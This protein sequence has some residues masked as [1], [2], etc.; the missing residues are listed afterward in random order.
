MY[1]AVIL[2]YTAVILMYTAVILMYT[3]VILPYTAVI[4]MY[5]AV[6]LPYTA[7]ILMYTAVILM[8]TAVILSAAK[9]LIYPL[10]RSFTT[11][12]MTNRFQPLSSNN[13]SLLKR[14]SIQY[15]KDYRQLLK[16]IMR[17]FSNF[18]NCICNN[19]NFK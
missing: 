17:H 3:A 13:S 5:T 10:Q 12:R 8:Y 18:K 6:I 14:P 11:F 15:K 7:V 1:T 19:Y 4:L 9:N 2:P 16:V